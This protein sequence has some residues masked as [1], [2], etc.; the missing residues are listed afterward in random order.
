MLVDPNGISF[1]AC[2]NV[3]Q[4]I[5]YT[6]ACGHR[7]RETCTHTHTNYPKIDYT[8]VTLFYTVVI[9]ISI[10]INDCSR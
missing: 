2:D 4:H 5:L 3:M 7:F 6:L 1:S 9:C 8:S 10:I